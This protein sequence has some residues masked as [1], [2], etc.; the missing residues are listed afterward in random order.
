MVYNQHHMR[1]IIIGDV[2]GCREEFAQLLQTVD[3]MPGRDDLVSVGDL[4]D[5]GPDPVG[6]VALAMEQKARLVR[7]NHEEKALR[8][9]RHEAKAAADP[10]YKNPMRPVPAERQG[11]WK[12]L[13]EAQVA[14]LR[15]SP[16]LLDLKNGWLAVHAGLE[17]GVSLKKQRDDRLVRVRYVDAT[18]EMVGYTDGSLDQPEGTVYWTEQWKGPQ[19]VVYGHAVH[20]KTEP[21]IDTF[22]G[23]NGIV[24]MIGIDT[25]CCFGGRLTAMILD[26]SAEPAFVQVQASRNYFPWPRGLMGIDSLD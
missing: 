17:P 14:Y 12:G 16:T 15:N 24:R 6:T 5:R 18:G 8:W 11:Q 26:G 4:L 2:H 3:Y 1:T 25:G 21:R 7:G 13:L 23:P 22:E 20:S 9:L 10:S 19:H